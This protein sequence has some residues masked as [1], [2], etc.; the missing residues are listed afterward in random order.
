MF[1]LIYF[2]CTILILNIFKQN[3][4]RFERIIKKKKSIK[5]TSYQLQFK[6]VHF[7]KFEFIKDLFKSLSHATFKYDKSSKCIFPIV[8]KNACMTMW[9]IKMEIKQS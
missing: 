6:K 5:L 7:K 3:W 8:F 4:R 9:S 1:H 2:L